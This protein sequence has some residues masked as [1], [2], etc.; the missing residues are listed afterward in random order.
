MVYT[1]AIYANMTTYI[2][3]KYQQV[4]LLNLNL[5]WVQHLNSKQR[6]KD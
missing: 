1:Y 2:H 3:N 5:L 4:N 6:Y